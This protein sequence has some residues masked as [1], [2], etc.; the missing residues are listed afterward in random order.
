MA[1]LLSTI[2]PFLFVLAVVYGALEVSDIFKKKQVK[3]IISLVF[4]LVAMTSE[5]ITSFIMGILPLATVGFIIFFFIGLALSVLGVKKGKEG[6]EKNYSLIAIILILFLI[7]LANYGID[8][9]ED[10]MP[11]LTTDEIITA[12]GILALLIIFYVAYKL[13]GKNDKQG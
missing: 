8:F 6:E 10:L 3:L 11:G 5:M 7:F 9:L 12:V 1:D 13:W 4:A 2:I